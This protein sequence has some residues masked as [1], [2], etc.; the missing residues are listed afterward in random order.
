M[1]K[2]LPFAAIVIIEFALG[3]RWGDIPPLG[4]FFSPYIGFW[5]NAEPPHIQPLRHLRIPQIEDSVVVI[6]DTRWIPHL[7]AR[8]E[9][10]L[11]RVQGYLQAY[12]R[13]W[14]MEMQSN[15]AAGCLS[16]YLGERTLEFDRAMRRL[17]M[18]VAAQRALQEIQKD[19]LS[20]TIL[21][22]FTQG[23]NAYIRSLSYKNLPLEY[24]LLD[25]EPESWSPLRSAYLIKY[26]AYDLSVRAPDKYLTRMLQRYTPKT[27]D[28]LYPSHLPISRPTLDP[29]PW[30][31]LAPP[32]MPPETLYST[33]YLMDSL[34]TMENDPEWL[35]SNN[36]A[37]D[38]K[39]TASGY[40][41]LAN[42]PHLRLTLPSIWLEMHLE[43]PGLST[44]GVSL[45]GAPGIIIGY[46]RCAAWGVTNVG[47]DAWDF[48]HLTYADPGRKKY[49]YADTILDVSFRIE[50]LY[51][52]GK[53]ILYDTVAYTHWGP[54]PYRK[55]ET[56]PLPLRGKGR[57]V[58]VDCAARWLGAEPSNELLTFYFL[59]RACG[60][61]DLKN[62]L[63]HFGSPAQNF[64][65]ADTLG[66]IAL[67]AAGKYPRKWK[68][69]GK[70]V[71]DAANPMHHWQG[72]LSLEEA[73]HE[74]NPLRHFVS[75]ANTVP[76]D[77]SYP[78]YLGW[79]FALPERATRIYDRL[80]QLTHATVDSL[81]H[82]QLDTY[83]PPAAWVL[84]K[85]LQLIDS[86]LDTFSRA[87]Q[88]W[89]YTYRS[90]SIAPSLY[91]KW[92]RAIHEAIWADDVPERLPEWDV[93]YHLVLHAPNWHWVDN[94]RTPQK[95]TLTDIVRQSWE[96]VTQW[97]SRINPDSLQWAYQRNMY[98]RHL[99]SIPGMGH[100][101]LIRAD[102]SGDVI[103]AIGSTSG[104][105]WRMVVDLT[106]P[107]K[108]Y[109]IYPGGQSGNPGSF[110][111]EDFID[112]WEKGE[113]IPAN[114][115]ASPEKFPAGKIEGT[116][117][118]SR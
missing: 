12:L 109:G 30:T 81:R 6:W 50:T 22:A 78:F 33:R 73:P 72:W 110:H 104:P 9:L 100:R 58:P 23:V 87:L 107:V 117:K 83:R 89:D 44:Y 52:R 90:Q 88:K 3:R 28:S 34:W 1:R 95:E 80:S 85:L 113:L 112:S 45:L 32:P 103:C 11:Y 13:L 75:S 35:G 55:G 98:I 8:K 74:I 18:P 70:Y 106:P 105:S 29:K 38:G 66:N 82:L 42:D 27:L 71:L 60:I 97:A 77:T 116:S 56:I 15:A 79:Y 25:Y 36:W 62:A 47:P 92:F 94:R 114:F 101:H 67:W 20:R 99:G 76:A 48:Y 31:V 57:E 96:K 14:Q 49:R 93:T 84:P 37:V 64:A 5:Q 68:D 24:K 39:R 4:K 2:V 16:K 26:M 69:Q 65:Y 43:A 40:P 17:G 51:V 102:G 59:N 7:Y 53:G 46:N 118:V 21:E 63:R 54:V 91:Q 61:E 19:S 111:Y 86:P 108:G 41:L 115:F 10:D